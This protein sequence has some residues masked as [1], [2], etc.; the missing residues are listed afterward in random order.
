M[1]LTNYTLRGMHT[2]LFS[3]PLHFQYLVKRISCFFFLSSKCNYY[4]YV[5]IYAYIDSSLIYYVH[6]FCVE[7]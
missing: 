6:N 3:I 5:K 7:N 2:M 1:Y 4:P